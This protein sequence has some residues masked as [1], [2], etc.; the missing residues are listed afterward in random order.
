MNKE[1]LELFSYLTKLYSKSHAQDYTKAFYLHG[2][3]QPLMFYYEGDDVK[4]TYTPK[5]FEIYFVDDAGNRI[6]MYRIKYGQAYFEVCPTWPK[7]PDKEGY[8]FK[9]W[10]TTD[11]T[12]E[13]DVPKETMPAEKLTLRK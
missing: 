2:D 3:G 4:A 7:A 12:V 8:T 11:D 10:Y 9:Y 13:F 6:A 1:N 5:T